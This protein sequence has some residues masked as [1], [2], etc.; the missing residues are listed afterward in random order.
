MDM[1]TSRR[2]VLLGMLL[3]SACSTQVGSNL[4]AGLP[5]AT[6]VVVRVLN[7]D[8]AAGASEVATPEMLSPTAPPVV[9]LLPTPQP[10][11]PVEAGIDP[12][13]GTP[14]CTNQAEF[15]RSLSISDNTALQ[16]GQRFAKIWRIKNIG[17]CQWTAGY[18][19]RFYS[20]DAMGGPSLVNLPNTVLPGE[21]VDIRVD[22]IAPGEMAS[23]SG[24]WVLSNAEGVQFGFGPNGDQVLSV[25][26]QVKP[27][28]RAAPS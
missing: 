7:L 10:E 15:I 18:S 8:I 20:G 28:P 3:L 12:T 16:A 25:V 13:P 22:L 9:F 2:L 27:T 14:A 5:T 23:Y 21:T 1:K 19:L 4:D 6:P 26:I 24:N 17:T 11:L